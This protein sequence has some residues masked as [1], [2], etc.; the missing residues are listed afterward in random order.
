VAATLRLVDDTIGA[1]R[2][3][4]LLTTGGTMEKRYVEQNGEMRNTEPQ[5]ARCLKLLRLP[6]L[7]VT[8]EQL[9]NKDSLEMTAADRE[10]IADHVEKAATQGLPVL[11]T[12][13]T[14]TVVETGRVVAARLPA[15]QTPVIFTG[16]MTPFGIEG[17]DAMQNLTE[18]LL[19]TQLVQPGVYLSFHGTVFPIDQVRKDREHS[20]FVSTQGA[21]LATG[22]AVGRG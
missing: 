5:I 13:G 15:L 20:R 4:H 14:D 9:M 7:E 1:M 8:V 22:E 12:H 18:A 16:A 11:V 10:C 2:R 21:E 17:S 6:D 19:A 3:V